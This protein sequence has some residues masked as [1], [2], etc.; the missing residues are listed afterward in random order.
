M[1]TRSNIAYKINDKQVKVIYCHWD[2]GLSNVG[3]TLVDCYDTP[4]KVKEL[5]DFGNIS[6]LGETLQECEVDYSREKGG[7]AC[8]SGSGML[9][10]VPTSRLGAPSAAVNSPPL[11]S[12]MLRSLS[13]SPLRSSSALI[14][15]CLS[16]S[17]KLPLPP[18]AEPA[19]TA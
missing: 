15:I 9:L 7:M 17:E 10:S 13:T 12:T 18:S 5:V 8:S 19:L 6:S 2:G 14:I 1:S 3:Q 11:P 4:N 16:L